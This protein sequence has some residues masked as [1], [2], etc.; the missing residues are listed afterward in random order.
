MIPN[1]LEQH[2]NH[3]NQ[4]V[5]LI[6]LRGRSISSTYSLHLLSTM[7]LSHVAL[8][9]TTTTPVTLSACCL[10]R[11][12]HLSP[13]PLLCPTSATSWATFPG[14]AHSIANVR[15]Y[16]LLPDSSSPHRGGSFMATAYTG[17][18]RC[19]R[20]EGLEES[21]CLSRERGKVSPLSSEGACRAPSNHRVS[22]T[23]APEERIGRRIVSSVIGTLPLRVLR[24]SSNLG[25]L[26][27]SCRQQLFM[28]ALR[29]FGS[30]AM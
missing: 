1:C 6:F 29:T 15:I 9:P 2:A 26:C 13:S 19:R 7:H 17:G 11:H 14:H 16:G 10:C 25:R 30:N 3:A 12:P 20:E 23:V 22:S 8:I 18:V 24:T 5:S 21:A 4:S 28:S 27:G